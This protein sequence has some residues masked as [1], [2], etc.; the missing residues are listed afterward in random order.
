MKALDIGCSVGYITV[1]MPPFV[2]KIIGTDIGEYA[3]NITK[4]NNENISNLQYMVAD[5][6]AL[7]FF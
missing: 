7:P 6:M 4:G 1:F 2:S 3:I 5:S